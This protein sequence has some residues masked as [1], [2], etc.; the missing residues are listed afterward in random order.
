MRVGEAQN[1]VSFVFSR[2]LCGSAAPPA[3]V[4]PDCGGVLCWLASYTT[5]CENSG[6]LSRS[7]KNTLTTHIFE[8]FS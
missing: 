3:S 4:R 7:V 8:K 6:K 1:Q 2:F 5:Q